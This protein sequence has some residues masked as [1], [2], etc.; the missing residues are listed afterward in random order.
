MYRNVIL[1]F[2]ATKRKLLQNSSFFQMT[3][4][5]IGTNYDDFLIKL[6]NKED[7]IHVYHVNEPRIYEKE[8]SF[9]NLHNSIVMMVMELK[10]Q[11]CF[12]YEALNFEMIDPF[13]LKDLKKINFKSLQAIPIF[14]NDEVCGVIILYYDSENQSL[15]FTNNELLKLL[16]EL[17]LDKEKNIQ[18]ELA[19]A[20]INIDDYYIIA[21]SKDLIYVNELVK[22]KLKITSS[23]LDR[24][25]TSYIGRINNLIGQIGIKKIKYAN[26]DVYYLNHNKILSKPFEK[27]VFSIYTLNQVFYDNKNTFLFVRINESI[28]ETLNKLNDVLNRIEI[29][30]YTLFQY[31]DDTFIYCIN[32]SLSIDDYQ[33]IKKAFSN[34]YLMMLRYQVDI[35]GKMNLNKLCDYL[36]IMQPDNFIFQNYV[37]W[38]NEHNKV[39]LA[40]NENY[41]DNKINYEI[42]SSFDNSM[43]VKMINLPLKG[44]NRNTH[45]K[46][47][48][49]MSEQILK[50]S[51][52]YENQPIM[53]NLSISVLEK[54]KNYEIIKKIINNNNTL[55][56]NV[57]NDQVISEEGV[58]KTLSKYKYLN[59]HLSCDSSV[60]LNINYMSMLPLFDAIYLQNVEFESIR[61]NEV[62]L[63]QAIMTYA[64]NQQMLVIMENFK[65]DGENDYQHASCYYVNYINKK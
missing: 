26:L 19:K 10:Q 35:N 29:S 14:E 13:Y 27:K 32:E 53:L 49:E 47:Y 48:N 62:G 43:L 44:E 39:S 40:Y 57:L 15:A 2:L 3:I 56:I 16:N 59:L 24:K 33:K 55:W 63:P 30:D 28:D 4:C 60:F 11:V 54:R 50:A 22:Q 6:I 46:M 25:T 38:L 18:N 58:L 9:E 8:Y 37:E 45:F 65:P 20:I 52:K 64:I 31:S 51:S 12:N 34:I 1:E 7:L 5:Q 23:V 36:F 21:M 41:Y 17:N 42:K 61:R